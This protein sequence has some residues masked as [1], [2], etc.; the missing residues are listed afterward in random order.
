MFFPFCSFSVSLFLL[1][2]LFS[3]FPSFPLCSSS[4]FLDSVSFAALLS[5]FSFLFSLFFSFLFPFSF[6][7]SSFRSFHFPRFA[8][9]P[10][11]LF[12]VSFAALLSFFLFSVFC[13][14]LSVLFSLFSFSPLCSSSFSPL[15]RF[16]RRSSFFFS[17][18]C[19]P[20]PSF[21]PFFALSLFPA[22]LLP[23]FPLFCFFLC[24]SFSP[25]FRF[26]RRSSFFFSLFRFLPI[27]FRIAN[28][29]RSTQAVLIVS[30]DF[31]SFPNLMTGEKDR[32]CPCRLCRCFQSIKKLPF[33]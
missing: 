10:F 20:F 14:L 33:A 21:C 24:S 22:L 12:S 27:F 19:F 2:V 13:F 6:F 1:S 29:S 5:F 8:L 25:L 26:F 30:N 31:L 4:F 11:P 15:F 32:F 28:F 16:F 9:L 18:F 23:L 17:L 7:L 3:L